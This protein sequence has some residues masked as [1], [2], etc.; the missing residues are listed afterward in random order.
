MYGPKSVGKTSIVAGLE[1]SL[2]IDTEAGSHQYECARIN[3]GNYQQLDTAITALLTEP[4]DYQYI[5]IDTI[6]QVDD[7]IRAEVCR[8]KGVSDLSEF[9]H[10]QG[11][12]RQRDKFTDFLLRLNG[13]IRLGKEVI[14]TGHSQVRTVSPPGLD[15]L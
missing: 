12:I 2:I 15:P 7:F 10:G 8:E 14:L 4:N 1:N 5:N 9:A 13:F 6:D 11:Y 3:V